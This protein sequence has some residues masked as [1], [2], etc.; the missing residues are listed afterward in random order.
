MI[1]I[2]SGFGLAAIILFIVAIIVPD[3]RLGWAGCA[4]LTAALLG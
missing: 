2:K 3:N 1:G 4:C